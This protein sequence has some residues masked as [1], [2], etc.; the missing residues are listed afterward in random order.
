MFKKHFCANILR[1]LKVQITLNKHS[2]KI[3][4]RT[5]DDNSERTLPECLC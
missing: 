3:T 1:T 4:E 2:I 5:L